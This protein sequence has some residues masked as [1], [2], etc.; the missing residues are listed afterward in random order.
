LASADEVSKEHSCSAVVSPGA[1]GR[2]V[3]RAVRWSSRA[4]AHAR[5]FG[6]G[7]VGGSE[8]WAVKR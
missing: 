2:E 6:L 4:K 3:P 5:V 1:R 8:A 7:R